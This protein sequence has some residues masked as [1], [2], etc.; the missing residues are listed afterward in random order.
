MSKFTKF[1][2]LALATL[3]VAGMMVF[4]AP[5]AAAYEPTGDYASD[6]ALLNAL[7]V[8]LGDGI[9]FNEKQ[10]VT[11]WQMALFIARIVTGE[12]GNEMW[13]AEKSAYYTDV[14]ATDYPGAIDFCYDM[15]Y[16]NGVG[17]NKFDPDANIIYQDALTLLVRLLGYETTD[18]KYPWGHILTAQDI[19]NV[20]GEYLTDDIYASYREPLLREEVANLIAKAIYVNRIGGYNANGNPIYKGTLIET[21]LKAADLGTATLVATYNAAIGGATPTEDLETVLFLVGEDTVEVDVAN[22]TKDADFHINDLLGF[23]ASLVSVSVRRNEVILADMNNITVVDKYGATD[24][25]FEVKSNVFTVGKTTYADAI[26]LKYGTAANDVFVEAAVTDAPVYGR[27]IIC[28]VA[29]DGK[30][31]NDI[32]RFVE[33]TRTSAVYAFNGTFS[34][35]KYDPLK[36]IGCVNGG[37]VTAYYV[38]VAGYEAKVLTSLKTAT[39]ANQLTGLNFGDLLGN[40]VGNGVSSK[41]TTDTARGTWGTNSYKATNYYV[42][43]MGD[44]VSG[45]VHVGDTKIIGTL[46]FVNVGKAVEIATG[47]AD[48]TGLTGEGEL[49]LGDTAFALGYAAPQGENNWLLAGADVSNLIGEKVE[50]TTANGAIIAVKKYVETE[51]EEEELTADPNT[52]EFFVL[53]FKSKADFT[54]AN[55]TLN[56]DG[57]ITLNTYNFT[58]GEYVDI[59]VSQ[60]NGIK[61]GALV[62]SFGLE[63]ASAMFGY[64]GETFAEV[65]YNYVSSLP[66]ALDYNTATAN[67]ALAIVAVANKTDDVYDITNNLANIKVPAVADVDVT[68]TKYIDKAVSLSTA[69]SNGTW[70]E[71][72]GAYEYA[73]KIFNATEATKFVAIA[74]DGIKVYEKFLPN[75]GDTLVIDDDDAIALAF[76]DDLVVVYTL[77]NAADVFNFST[78][79]ATSDDAEG[80]YFTLTWKTKYEGVAAKRD[81]NDVLYYEYTF[82]GV[83]NLATGANETLVVVA[84]EYTDTPATDFFAEAWKG[85]TSPIAAA[86]LSSNKLTANGA[87]AQAALY[88][89]YYYDESLEE[90]ATVT[91]EEF[92]AAFKYEI[93]V[94]ENI[95]PKD[96]NQL[97]IR[98]EVNTK[99]VNIVTS[100]TFDQYKVAK[101]DAADNIKTAQTCN[102]LANAAAADALKG[103]TVL[104]TLN[105][106]TGECY[107]I[108]GLPFEIPFSWPAVLNPANIA[109]DISGI[110]GDQAKCMISGSKGIVALSAHAPS[111]ADQIAV[112]LE[113]E[114]G[115]TFVR[116]ANNGTSAYN[117]LYVNLD[118]AV[119]VDAGDYKITITYRFDEGYEAVDSAKTDAAAKRALL[120]RLAYSTNSQ[121]DVAT[122]SKTAYDAGDF[123]DW[124]TISGTVNV[125]AA[126][127]MIRI[128]TFGAA[129]DYI[130]VLSVE[131]EPAE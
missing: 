97:L 71:E 128:L 30:T 34:D 40:Y 124:A 26:F 105:D 74:A 86:N 90:P 11:R 76:S 110:K 131:I 130:D 62:N 3:M 44:F 83:R 1:L 84:Y 109:Q 88:T 91:A 82:S 38:P 22:L 95:V 73:D 79:P 6:I 100:Y 7:D 119:F 125:S 77:N 18:T 129:G 68:F 112:S 48:F 78:A 35:M 55:V 12:T 17:D 29:N 107:F 24:K 2:A 81:A 20:K 59:T 85:T 56:A 103:Q 60:I 5:A 69:Y 104:Y 49:K 46:S 52:K 94:I 66:A 121:K 117:Q 98:N 4:T 53:N 43:V 64:A 67:Q 10:E 93:G 102:S 101:D 15:G 13:E 72:A 115:D 37:A 9:S 58:T 57:T 111:A 106:K 108:V 122:L 92:A 47:T 87:T 127:T 65:V 126:P 75:T 33:F 50:Y 70:D 120:V 96:A 123:T 80:K 14:D 114:D 42:A 99:T 8:M 118:P 41:A 51:E 113:E 54:N 23:T 39:T 16:M 36:A 116:F 27:A 31:D 19:D 45:Q 25:A 63:V 32:V 61:L 28:D 21:G 89:V